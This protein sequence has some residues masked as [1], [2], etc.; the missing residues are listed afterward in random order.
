MKPTVFRYGIFATLTV[1]VLSWSAFFLARSASFAVQ[2]AVGYLSIFISM[3]F[4]FLGIRHYRDKFN[5]GYLSFGQGLKT[6]ILIVL[7]PAVFFGLFD[8]LYTEVINPSWMD[9]YYSHAVEQMK[10]TTD[11]SRLDAALK[12]MEAQR[13]MF[14]SPVMQFLLMTATVLVIGLI[15]TILSSLALMRRKRLNTGLSL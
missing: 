10:K 3:I 2:E 4:V 15:V 7:L 13:E 6:G 11:P 12:K 8:I 1:L 5:G 14:A 9:D